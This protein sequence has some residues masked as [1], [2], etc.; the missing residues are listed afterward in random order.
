M[1]GHEEGTP[2]IHEYSLEMRRVQETIDGPTIERLALVLK[3]DYFHVEETLVSVW[4]GDVPATPLESDGTTLVA[5]L[6]TKPPE[7]AEIVVR[8]G[9]HV[10]VA[11]EPFTIKRLRR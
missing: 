6:Y 4:V 7:G 10:M 5:L 8:Q 3:G 1:A 9:H 11:P 2:K